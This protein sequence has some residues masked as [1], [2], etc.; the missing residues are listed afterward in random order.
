MNIRTS[1][2]G[3]LLLL[4]ILP[5]AAAQIVTLL[6]VMR[7]VE[8]DVDRRARESLIIGGA[9][10]N[11][12][13]AG[14]AEQLRASVEV[15]AAD[16][17][18]KEAA[19]SGDEAT[20]QS[21][22][23]NHSR[24]VG[25]DVALLL[26]LD[27][28]GVAS[29]NGETL[30]SQDDYLRLIA[31]VREKSS[32][33]STAMLGGETY[34]TFTVPVRAPV[35]IAWVVL[36]FQIDSNL[37]E[38]IRGLTGLE[39]SIV[40]TTAKE[41]RTITTTRHAA[42]E[43]DAALAGPGMPLNTIYMVDEA[44]LASLTL[45][46]PFVRSGNE[47]LIVLQ[48]SLQ[49]AMAPYTEA[50]SGLFV[51]AAI[52]LILVAAAAGWFSGTVARPLRVLSDAARKMI[53]GNYDM[54]IRVRTN[55][56]F[57]ELASSFNAMRTAI[58]D[59]EKRISHQ[60]LHDPLTDLPNRAKIMQSLTEAIDHARS[61]NANVTILSIMLSRMNEISSTLG[62]SASD[63]VITLAAR[64]L[65]VNLNPGEVLGHVGTNEFIIVLPDSDIDNAVTYADRI[66]RILGAGVTLHRV[67][68]TL[69]TE[70]GISGFPEHGD[71][72]AVLLRYASIAR[73]EAKAH[74]ERVMVYEA[75]REDH[76]VRQLRIV[77]DLR[78]ALQRNEI[79][80]YFQP[81]ISL[82]DGEI[83]GA[84]ALVRWE[85]A[86]LGWLSP[87]DFIP[88]AEQSGTIVHLTR[89]VLAAAV[90][91]CREWRDA[92]HSLRVS[93]NLSSRDLQDEYLPYYVLQLL[94]EHGVPPNWLTLEMTE[95]SMMQDLQHAITVLECLRDIGVLISMDDFGTGH[96]SL[97]QIRNMPLHE[98]KIDK[99]FITTFLSDEQNREI[100]HTT[101]EL[102]H[103][104]DLR[105]VAEGIEDEQTLRQ[106][107]DLGCE[108]AQG[109]F[110]SK[111]VS[112]DALIDWMENREQT[113]YAERRKSKRAFA[114][115]A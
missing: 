59:R 2:R 62:H 86:E 64:H 56:E 60:A 52:L 28:V 94:K 70:I 10:V 109:Y 114:K 79:R 12:F 98:I 17:G 33:Q 77:N 38:R 39:V 36:G 75:G 24:R 16:Y 50:R 99:S 74:K 8:E 76:Y 44:G 3:K 58:A 100:V 34:H 110:L 1:F 11:E 81:K 84:E 49:E 61:G 89:F 15:L 5:L 103:N 113:S 104:M 93:V 42:G 80:V 48:R 78:A 4:T 73:S 27:G 7:T 57:G 37:A 91:Q 20:I 92:G 31:N 82:P 46:T 43:T 112:S 63:E 41:T 30:G 106:I 47:V 13:L 32:A 26:D 101:I 68:I 55:D 25:A 102:A 95:N 65:R 18:L 67:N 6:A 66:E 19:A 87:D 29:S 83:C 45:S 53:S 111:P 40:S 51:F 105:V 85:H 21:V 107:S 72:A 97:A 71:N 69:Q 14:R 54:K 90:K 108:E 9:V 35:A 23:A 96:S 22:L 88:A 115:K